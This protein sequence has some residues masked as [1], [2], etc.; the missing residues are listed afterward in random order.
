MQHRLLN[1]ANLQ[2]LSTLGKVSRYTLVVDFEESK[3]IAA[4]EVT[5]VDEVNRKWLEGKCHVSSS[6][7]MSSDYLLSPKVVNVLVQ[8]RICF[9]ACPTVIMNAEISANLLRPSRAMID[10]ALPQRSIRERRAQNSS[11]TQNGSIEG[12]TATVTG[13]L[14]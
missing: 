14:S 6:G 9:G 13:S 7:F 2:G 10:I 1:S 11:E 3:G 8:V 5:L 12:G 4:F